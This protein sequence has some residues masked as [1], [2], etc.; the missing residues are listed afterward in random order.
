MGTSLGLSSRH[1]NLKSCGGINK[2]ILG[3]IICVVLQF[4]M[5]TSLSVTQVPTLYYQSNLSIFTNNTSQDLITN[6][7]VNDY[8]IIRQ[9]L[10]GKLDIYSKAN[11]NLIVSVL[12]GTNYLTTLKCLE[13]DI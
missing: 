13:F 9:S 4:E 7:L 6:L 1:D 11:K 10:L 8:Y 3:Y 5:F 2:Q 12:S